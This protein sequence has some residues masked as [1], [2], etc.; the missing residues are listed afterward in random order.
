MRP[1]PETM[2]AVTVFSKPNGEPI[3]TTHSPTLSLP[4]S[5]NLTAGSAPVGSILISAMSDRLSLPITL[6]LNS[7]LSVSL[8]V[9]SSAPSTT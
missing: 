4:G 2:P 7:R 9:I 3:A 1:L 6:A 5:P 8:T